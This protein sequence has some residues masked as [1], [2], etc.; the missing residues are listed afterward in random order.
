MSE[1]RRTGNQGTSTWKVLSR[2]KQRHIA[3]LGWNNRGNEV[4][5]GA[6]ADHCLPQLLPILPTKLKYRRGSVTYRAFGSQCVFD[7]KKL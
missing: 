1:L 2:T 7:L 6:I 3:H 5:R 4:N